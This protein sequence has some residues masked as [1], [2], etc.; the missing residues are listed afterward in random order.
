MS[1]SRYTILSCLV[2]LLALSSC[3]AG[4]GSPLQNMEAPAISDTPQ[5]AIGDAQSAIADNGSGMTKSASFAT[6]YVYSI[7]SGYAYMQ[8]SNMYRYRGSVNEYGVPGL[9]HY[10]MVMTSQ[11]GTKTRVWYAFKGLGPIKLD[12]LNVRGN[13][14]NLK[15]G[16]F[17]KSAA[18]PVWG[19]GTAQ[20][21]WFAPATFATG[22]NYY[23]ASLPHHADSVYGVGYSIVVLEVEGGGTA[24]LQYLQ[25]WAS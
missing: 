12:K 2:A 23:L 25:A 13:C 1:A 17:Y 16:V 5:E 6:S 18:E 11:V 8:P 3:S 19:I 15:V 14:T 24:W 21:D 20:Y 10:G 22:K 9:S 7:G 4:S